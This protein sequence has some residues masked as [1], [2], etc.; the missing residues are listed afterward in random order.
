[1]SQATLLEIHK[2]LW[3][4]LTQQNPLPSVIY[5]AQW[6]VTMQF[7]SSHYYCVVSVRGLQTFLPQITMI[8]PHPNNCLHS[9]QL[10]YHMF[11]HPWPRLKPL[12]QFQLCGIVPLRYVMVS[13]QPCSLIFH[14]DSTQTDWSG[15]YF[16]QFSTDTLMG[17]YPM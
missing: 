3:K 15:S 17:R 8:N 2:T 13:K 1:M 11:G 6:T 4:I 10:S 5:A 7:H 9:N 12:V 14:W 16:H